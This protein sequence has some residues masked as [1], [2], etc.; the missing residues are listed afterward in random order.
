M[1]VKK[2]KNLPVPKFITP[3]PLPPPDRNMYKRKSN[4]NLPLPHRLPTPAFQLPSPVR[5][6]SLQPTYNGS[7]PSTYNGPIH[8]S[9]PGTYNGS[10]P[11]TYNKA[12]VFPTAKSL[13]NF[14]KLSLTPSPSPV[15]TVIPKKKKTMKRCKK[16]TRRNK[17]TMLCEKNKYY[18]RKKFTKRQF[19]RCPNGKRRNPITLQC[20][21][22]H[23][24]TQSRI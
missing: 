21:S 6:D 24:F 2:F 3:I 19:K 8:A 5:V 15:F 1:P 22:E 14:K 4:K 12:T 16:G 9:L 10:L 20:E 18:A 17:K 13:D 11:G 7:M 23:L